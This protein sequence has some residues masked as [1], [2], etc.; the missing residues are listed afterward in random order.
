MSQPNVERAVGRLLTDEGFRR[1]FTENATAAIEELIDAGFEL[2]ACERRALVEIPP[3]TACRFA[4][5]LPACIQRV[6]ITGGES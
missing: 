4:D 6:E 1:R 2:N 5:S 3:R